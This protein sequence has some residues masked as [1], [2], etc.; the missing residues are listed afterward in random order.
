MCFQKSCMFVLLR[1]CLL[2][3]LDHVFVVQL[4][5]HADTLRVEFY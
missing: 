1:A 4:V 2:V 5:I 3:D